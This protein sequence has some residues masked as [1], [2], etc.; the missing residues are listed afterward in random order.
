MGWSRFSPARSTRS[1]TWSRPS[2]LCRFRT[3][4][5]RRPPVAANLAGAMNHLVCQALEHEFPAAPEFEAEV[6]SSNL[7]KVFEV[8]SQAA[9]GE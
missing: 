9:A 6:K 7:K 4:S 8:V 3:A 2:G 5:S 1:T